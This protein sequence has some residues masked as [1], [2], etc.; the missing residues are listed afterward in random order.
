MKQSA[1][2]FITFTSYKGGVGK[3]TSAV[4]LSCLFSQYGQVLLIDSDP[5]RSATTWSKS[6]QL[7]FT[8]A[9]ENTATRY[10]A[11]TQFDFVVIDTPARPSE[12]ELQELVEGCDLLLLP[13]TPDSLSI[14]ATALT[15]KS[16]PKGTNYYVLLTMI[17][18]P[19]QKD[20]QDALNVFLE[21][22][23]PVLGKGI[24]AFKVY[25]EAVALGLPVYNVRGG[26]KVWRDWTELVKVNPI[27]GLLNSVIS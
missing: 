23:F 1:T 3:T 7:P 26:K 2:K 14:N 6:G 24:R 17:P 19:P 4:C 15:I 18:P 27:S 12:S 25:K 9:T 21:S 8:I 20:G 11:N 10:M 22:G 5:N 13:T 16:I